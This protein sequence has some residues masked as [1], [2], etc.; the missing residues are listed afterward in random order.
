MLAVFASRTSLA[1]LVA[2]AV[3]RVVVAPAPSSE[4]PPRRATRLG[5]PGASA[6]TQ[7]VTCIVAPQAAPS[8]E[9]AQTRFRRAREATAPRSS[10]DARPDAVVLIQR[11]APFLGRAWSERLS[12]TRYETRPNHDWCAT[13]SSPSIISTK[14]KREKVGPLQWKYVRKW[15]S[16]TRKNAKTTGVANPRRVLRAVRNRLLAARNLLLEMLGS[17]TGILNRL[18]GDLRVLLYVCKP[19]YGHYLTLSKVLGQD[20]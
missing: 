11:P 6:I 13:T 9:A 14:N 18:A 12:L 10:P 2:I 7:A 3:G 5:A 1:A 16:K 15:T 19:F 20:P 4:T 17:P 8:G